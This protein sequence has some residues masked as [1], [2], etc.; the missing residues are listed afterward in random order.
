MPAVQFHI[1]YCVLPT[2]EP[3]PVQEML[4]WSAVAG[5]VQ[6]MLVFVHEWLAVQ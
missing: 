2:H 3:S 6:N 1:P 4:Q 5:P